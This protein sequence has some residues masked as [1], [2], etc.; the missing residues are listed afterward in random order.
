MERPEGVSQVMFPIIA[1]RRQNKETPIYSQS[2]KWEVA[3]EGG[4]VGWGE[5]HHE[6]TQS[7][8]GV[9]KIK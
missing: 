9:N 8:I 3:G 5:L 4:L 1:H 7:S 2:L 6:K